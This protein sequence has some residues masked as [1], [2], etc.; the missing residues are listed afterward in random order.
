LP[1]HPFHAHTQMHT[2][3]HTHIH[4][5][6]L[7]REDELLAMF[8]SL[9]PPGP[10]QAFVISQEMVCSTVCKH[11]H[12]HAYTHLHTHTDAHTHK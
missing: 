4:T 12:T 3:T 7:L 10:R 1:Q 8:A 9:L 2:H 6:R 11:K 5:H